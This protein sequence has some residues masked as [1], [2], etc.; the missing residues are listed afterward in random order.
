MVMFA[1]FLLLAYL[2]VAIGTASALVVMKG[3]QLSK[4]DIALSSAVWPITMSVMIG[5]AGEHIFRSKT[6]SGE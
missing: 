2:Y 5:T 3:L 6:K 1:L 4:S